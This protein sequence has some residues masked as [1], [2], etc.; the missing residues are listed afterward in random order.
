MTMQVSIG[1]PDMDTLFITTAKHRLSEEE[2]AQQPGR[3]STTLELI[4]CPL[5]HTHHTHCLTASSHL[6]FQGKREG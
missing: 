4:D 3:I 1:G 2:R 5:L 6:N